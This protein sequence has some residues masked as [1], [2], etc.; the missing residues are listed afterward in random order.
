MDLGFF[1]RLH[2]KSTSGL[3]YTSLEPFMNET[4]IQTCRM[5]FLPKI[6]K[7]SEPYVIP[8][9]LIPGKPLVRPICASIGWVTYNV[10]T[11]LDILLRPLVYGIPTYIKNS[12]SLIKILETKQFPHDTTFLAA[13][14]ESLY[15][16]IDIDEGL[17]ALEMTMLRA[18]WSYDKIELTLRLTEWVLRNN[19]VEFN[20]KQ[21]LQLQGTAMGTPCAVVFACLF[22]AD[23]EVQIDKDLRYMDYHQ[24]LLNLRFIDDYLIACRTERQCHYILER[25]NRH[26]KNI[27]VTG[28]IS[29]QEAIFLDLL[30]YKGPR[31]QESNRLDI[32]LYE[33]PTNKF[34]YL[35]GTSYHPH[36][37]NRGWIK[38]SV[39]RL[40]L[41]NTQPS[42]YSSGIQNLQTRLSA[43]GHDLIPL[44]DIINN[45]PNRLQL[46]HNIQPLPT[47]TNR[48]SHGPTV[49]KLRATPRTTNLL[50]TLRQAFSTT[51]PHL[52][53]PS[54]HAQFQGKLKPLFCFQNDPNIGQR[55][56]TAKL[57]NTVKPPT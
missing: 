55:I 7:M 48:N 42:T 9:P 29:Q 24:P 2:I 56:I 35:P 8:P 23:L 10:S 39:Q 40:S 38:T 45:R 19:V 26:R 52:Q 49:L 13:D 33:K 53:N 44:L 34:L 47:C 11:Y 46:I 16:S 41:R 50:P 12:D 17:K 27:K 22:M 25:L 5:Y 21:Y 3:A 54:I 18:H 31:L 43:R 28:T 57:S 32:Q 20:G 15:P 6:H 51:R 1:S 37:V 36:H 4:E 30:I 14:V